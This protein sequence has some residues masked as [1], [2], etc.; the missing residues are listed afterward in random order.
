MEAGDIFLVDSLKFRSF[1]DDLI[2]QN[3]WD[4]KEKL[5]NELEIKTLSTPIESQ[6]SALEQELE[7]KIKKV[8]Q[9]IAQGENL[10]V[11]LIG[12]GENQ[13]WT[14]PYVKEDESINN[15]FYRSLSQISVNDVL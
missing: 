15:P 7:G 13:R 4:N 2:S 10:G 12:Q 1:E 8:N 3:E 11:K 5:I 6:L 14:L 9:R